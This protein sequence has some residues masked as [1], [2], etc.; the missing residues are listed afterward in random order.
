MR[1]IKEFLERRKGKRE[2]RQRMERRE[3]GRRE[4]V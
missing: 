2:V 3:K 1:K 4:G